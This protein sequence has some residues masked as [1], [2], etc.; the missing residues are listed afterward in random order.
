MV[1][2]LKE[3]NQVL[4]NQLYKLSNYSW[5]NFFETEVESSLNKCNK[6]TP[7]SSE[8]SGKASFLK[9]WKHKWSRTPQ[10]AAFLFIQMFLRD[11]EGIE[12]KSD[13]L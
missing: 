10:D 13:H 5:E 6:K 8:D 7:T 9:R 11:L 1:S 3:S 2:V 12:K 4:S